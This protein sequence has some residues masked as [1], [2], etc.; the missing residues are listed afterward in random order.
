MTLRSSSTA[1][2]EA[3]F[4]LPCA[5]LLHLLNAR[6]QVTYA[7]LCTAIDVSNVDLAFHT[8]RTISSYAH[9]DL[10][11]VY[12]DDR[13]CSRPLDHIIQHAFDKYQQAGVVSPVY[14]DMA[15][16]VMGCGDQDLDAITGRGQYIL[17]GIF[18]D[19]PGLM[20]LGEWTRV[21]EW[22]QQ[23]GAKVDGPLLGRALESTAMCSDEAALVMIEACWPAT[24]QRMD[25]RLLYAAV[26]AR[27]GVNVVRRLIWGNAPIAICD[28][29]E[30][31]QSPVVDEA[32]KSLLRGGICALR[33]YPS[34][35]QVPP[36]HNVAT[37]TIFQPLCFDKLTAFYLQAQPHVEGVKKRKVA[38][39][40]AAGG[41]VHLSE[42]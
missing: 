30:L 40:D 4:F 21:F 39:G 17:R 28:K 41:L 34:C 20:K 13:R 19:Q 18:E 14:A 9:V 31:M 27:R 2:P 24:V 3:D 35:L 26:N 25:A 16:F 23:H 5:G 37:P 8:L 36:P 10:R 32:V 7:D 33:L 15:M 6:Y 38:D 29:H 42:T 22:L 1:L 12:A 11:A